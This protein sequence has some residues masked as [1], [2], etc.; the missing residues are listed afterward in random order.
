M[1]KCPAMGCPAVPCRLSL[2]I[3]VFIGFDGRVGQNGRRF[4]FLHRKFRDGL[5]LALV[6]KLEILFLERTYGVP[7]CIPYHHRHKHQVHRRTEAERRIVLGNL[8]SVLRLL[9]T[10]LSLLAAC[11][12][13]TNCSRADQNSR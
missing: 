10:G 9:A 5:Q 11:L 2:R 13:K 6:E 12:R 8:G 4:G 3:S 1:M 7:L